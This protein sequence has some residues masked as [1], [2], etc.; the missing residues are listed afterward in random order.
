LNMPSRRSRRNNKEGWKVE[1]K[2]SSN[3]PLQNSDQPI[4]NIQFG[5][6]ATGPEIKVALRPSV[7]VGSTDIRRWT[8]IGR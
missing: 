7:K 1:G 4:T 3:L 8:Q 6:I 5:V 2:Q